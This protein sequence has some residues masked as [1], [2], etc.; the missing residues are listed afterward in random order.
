MLSDRL[1]LSALYCRIGQKKP[2]H[3][4]RLIA[5]NTLESKVLEI[6][7]RKNRLIQRAFSEGRGQEPQSVRKENRLAELAE[8]FGVRQTSATDTYAQI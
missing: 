6:Q 2:V 7:D 5:E 1:E 4:Y 3:V 8:L